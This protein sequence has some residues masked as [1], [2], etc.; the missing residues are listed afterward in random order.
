MGYILCVFFYR[1][2]DDFLEKMNNIIFFKRKLWF[3]G[4][5]YKCV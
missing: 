2:G 4:F 3:G 5:V 1:A